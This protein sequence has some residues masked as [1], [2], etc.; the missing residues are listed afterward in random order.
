MLL[1]DF[2]HKL[3]GEVKKNQCHFFHLVAHKIIWMKSA[4]DA[5]WLARLDDC[6]VNAISFF[7]P[8]CLVYVFS[9]T[10]CPA[11]YILR[12]WQKSLILSLLIKCI[13]ENHVDLPERK[14]SL[15]DCLDTGIGG[16]VNKMDA[17]TIWWTAQREA[18]RFCLPRMISSFTVLYL[19][20]NALIQGG[21]LETRGEKGTS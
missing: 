17:Q 18:G 2:I 16:R 19:Y 14:R 20:C 3:E 13:I 8:L 11:P 15:H 10:F 6:V 7:L 21:I 1:G 12:Y 9:A 5:K 4:S